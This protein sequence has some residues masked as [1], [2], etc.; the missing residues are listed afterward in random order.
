MN[1]AADEIERLQKI[2]LIAEDVVWYDWSNNDSDAVHT[3]DQLRLALAAL[4]P[5]ETKSP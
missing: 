3:M 4:S 5:A 1:A 2:R